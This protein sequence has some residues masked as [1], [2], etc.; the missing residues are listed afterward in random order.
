L[1]RLAG[2]MRGG[3][4]DDEELPIAAP[5]TPCFTLVLRP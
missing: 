3:T 5:E 4:V 2:F 1:F